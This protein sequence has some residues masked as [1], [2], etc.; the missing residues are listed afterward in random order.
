MSTI[1]IVLAEKQYS[2]SKVLA[3]FDDAVA[4]SKFVETV[5]SAEPRYALSVQPIELQGRNLPV[6]GTAKLAPLPQLPEF[7]VVYTDTVL[8]P[9][10]PKAAVLDGG[11]VKGTPM[12]GDGAPEVTRPLSTAGRAE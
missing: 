6:I 8:T 4:A 12:I 2:S 11:P 3:A 5:N 10:F 1:H 7:D 9:L